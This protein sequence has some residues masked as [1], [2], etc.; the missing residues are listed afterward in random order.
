[1]L[2]V[3]FRNNEEVNQMKNAKAFLAVLLLLGNFVV[4]GTL[5]GDSVISDGVISKDELT[6]GSYCHMK[7]PGIDA[8]SLASANPV[9]KD[10]T[11]GDIIDFYGP[12][13][14][15]PLGQDQVHAQRL[16]FSHR[17]RGRSQ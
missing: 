13:D 12:C 5:A 16:D 4:S 8:R 7:F 17:W 1:L 14:E 6:P 9:L 3:F 15:N 11:A 2:K 10:W